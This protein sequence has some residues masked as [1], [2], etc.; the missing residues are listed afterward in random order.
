M[1]ANFIAKVVESM[2]NKI[3]IS[4]LGRCLSNEIQG[5]KKE[6]NYGLTPEFQNVK[7]KV[8]MGK[9]SYP[10]YNRWVKANALLEQYLQDN[11]DT[12]VETELVYKW[13]KDTCDRRSQAKTINR[14]W[15]TNF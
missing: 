6:N 12:F 14:A 5:I 15:G 8:R 13:A 2:Y 3:N 11:P 9:T 7:Y 4:E 10:P 1:T